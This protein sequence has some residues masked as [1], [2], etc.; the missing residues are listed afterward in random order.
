MYKA[1]AAG[2]LYEN[3]M[4]KITHQLEMTGHASGQTTEDIDKMT[5]ALA[6]N[7]LAS[8]QGA[9]DAATAILTFTSITGDNVERTLNLA[10][11]LTD[12][13]GGDLLANAKKLGKMFEDP[14]KAFEALNEMGARLSD[15][16]KERLKI[17]AATGDHLGAQEALFAKIESR[18]KGISKAGATDTLS[19]AYDT[20]GESLTLLYEAISKDSGMLKTFKDA[21]N[22]ISESIQSWT[23]TI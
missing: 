4:A 19:G 2:S 20:L 11:D 5:K 18:V 1:V 21:I 23:K 15:T 17:M 22:S 9:R 16:E 14:S 7:T 10:Q 3:S 6:I 13:L 8:V 12:S